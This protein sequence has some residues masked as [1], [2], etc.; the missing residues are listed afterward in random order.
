MCGLV[1]VINKLKNGFLDKQ[2]T[3]FEN[4]LY[5]DAMRGEDST[6][7]FLVTTL[8]NVYIAKEAEESTYFLKDQAW[9][10]IRSKAFASGWGLIGHN[11]KATRG[12]ITDQN[13]HPFWVDDKLV[14]VHNGS[15]VGDHKHLA[16][17]T[18]DS[19]AI[20]HVLAKEP[21][22]EKAL[23]Q[24]N[25]AY[26]LIWYDVENKKMNIIRNNERPLFWIETDNAF[27]FASE[28]AMLYLALWRNG[29]KAINK[30]GI[31]EIFAE[32]SLS[33]FYMDGKIVNT[34][35]D[36]KYVAPP[37]PLSVVDWRQIAR[38]SIDAC[39][40]PG[41]VQDVVD[42]SQVKDI[43]PGAE[44]RPAT[45]SAWQNLREARYPKG[46]MVKVIVNDYHWDIN[47]KHSDV[48]LM[49]HTVDDAR[50][51]V[52]VQ[53]DKREIRRLAD[54]V[55][56]GEALFN[57][58]IE[59]CGWAPDRKGVSITPNTPGHI[60]IVSSKYFNLMETQQ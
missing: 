46:R 44:V 7:A 21:D 35:L 55:R 32:H 27:Y 16:D 23:K 36:C 3:I 1:G 12:S 14:L 37:T 58:V 5:I 34:Q 4:L 57:V 2:L 11:R 43:S 6:G 42:M 41:D 50:A 40:L 15:L 39:A 51:F 17:V 54:T 25:G 56:S 53:A 29:V 24:I 22:P 52:V 60:R 13:A 49:G 48:F 20:A 9:A 38:D 8:G 26:A 59:N 33:E 28:N 10:D 31:A 30:D 19:E 47:D 18:V 45:F